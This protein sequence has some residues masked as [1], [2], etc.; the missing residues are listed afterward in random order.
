MVNG[1]H[2]GILEG[3]TQVGKEST[4][5]HWHFTALKL[6]ERIVCVGY[7]FLRNRRYCDQTPTIIFQRQIH[8][9]TGTQNVSAR[10]T[11]SM[12]RM[13]QNS[14]DIRCFARCF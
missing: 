1:F 13:A 7:V 6:R 5:K 14:R 10:V 12:Y 9:E 3:Y 8:L 4:S 11:K 2:V